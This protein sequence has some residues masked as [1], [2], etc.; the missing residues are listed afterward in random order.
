MRSV[1]MTYDCAPMTLTSTAQI[2]AQL[3]YLLSELLAGNF[4]RHESST[5]VQ[6]SPRYRLSFSLLNED[7]SSQGYAAGWDV[8]DALASTSYSAQANQ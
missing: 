1:V 8:E 4:A 5:V 2:D 7:A 6:Y 3:T